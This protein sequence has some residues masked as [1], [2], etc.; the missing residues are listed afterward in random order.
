MVPDGADIP[1]KDGL[2]DPVDLPTGLR[3]M[4]EGR[5]SR[6][7]SAG[8]VPARV[9][10]CQ[11]PAVAAISIFRP[12]FQSASRSSRCLAPRERSA[13]AVRWPGSRYGRRRARPAFEAGRSAGHSRLPH[14][15][16]VGAG[17]SARC[18]A[19]QKRPLSPV[20]TAAAAG[21]EGRARRR[22]RRS[23]VSVSPWNRSSGG[24]GLPPRA[25]GRSNVHGCGRLRP[26]SRMPTG[27]SATA[28]PWATRVRTAWRTF[29]W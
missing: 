29:S 12:R 9:D 5:G 6:L 22:A 8:T 11:V 19:P 2:P 3:S 4:P 7:P 23:V 25:C 27:L 15:G 10:S 26:M 1:L 20:R 13:V 28:T 24:D 18:R 21:R 17:S 16:P 14:G